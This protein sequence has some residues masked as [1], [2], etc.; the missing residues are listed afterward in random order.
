[1]SRKARLPCHSLI[2][3]LVKLE[4]EMGKDWPNV[5]QGISVRLRSWC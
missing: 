5:T 1:M 2:P 4:L 3:Q